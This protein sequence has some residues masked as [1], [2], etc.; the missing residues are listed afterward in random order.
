MQAF[1]S[2]MHREIE[3]ERQ[4]LREDRKAFE[5]L[6]NANSKTISHVGELE[7]E[8]EES[9]NS[10]ANAKH[11]MEKKFSKKIDKIKKEILKE[12]VGYVLTNRQQNQ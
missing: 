12:N 4:I 6:V 1:K 5:S 3:E 8:D 2:S 10:K 11:D 9:R 7:D